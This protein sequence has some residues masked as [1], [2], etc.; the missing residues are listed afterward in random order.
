MRVRVRRAGWGWAPAAA[1]ASLCFLVG[2]AQE[3]SGQSIDGSI[4]VRGRPAIGAV[5]ELVPEGM[6]QP[7][8]AAAAADTSLIDQLHLRFAPGVLGISAGSVVEF[9]NSD[10]ILHNVFSPPRLGADFDLGTYPQNESRTHTFNSPGRYV[11]LCHVHPEMAAWVVVAESRL[12]A[13]TDSVGRFG[14]DEVPAGRYTTKVW[15]RRLDLDGGSVSV[16]P[17]GTTDLTIALGG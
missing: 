12:V 10:A 1:T 4:T 3:A 15:Y 7:E 11:I 17:Q 2:G 6:P 13:V 16:A 5:V 9:R 14:L 8:V